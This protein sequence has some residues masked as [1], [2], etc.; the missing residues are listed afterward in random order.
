MEEISRKIT[1]AEKLW[2]GLLYGRITYRGNG[3]DPKSFYADGQININEGYLSDVPII[4]SVFNLLNLTLPK[5]ES[6]HSAQT[7]FT[8]KDGIIHVNEGKVYSDT[9]ELN[10]KGD[11]NLKGDLHLNIVAG[12]SK[13]F[14]SQIPIVGRLFEFIV[15]G[16]RKQLTMVEIRGTFLKPESHSVPFKSF[17]RSIKSMFDLLPKDERE[18]TTHT[19]KKDS[20]EENPF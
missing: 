15:G 8:V 10:G 13:D 9:V 1:K 7:K 14:F 19:E 3:A 6:F 16:V 12:F 11:I 17:T 20:G 2:S 18:T 4:L 5:K